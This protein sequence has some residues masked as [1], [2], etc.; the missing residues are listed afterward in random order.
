M[1][2]WMLT[3]L[4]TFIISK[5]IK[6]PRNLDNNKIIWTVRNNNVLKWL[7]F[8]NRE[9]ISNSSYYRPLRKVLVRINHLKTNDSNSGNK[10]MLYHPPAQALSIIIHLIKTQIIKIKVIWLLSSINKR[11]YPLAWTRRSPRKKWKVVA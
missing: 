5:M 6:H 11:C 3:R 8:I 9:I 7:I 4:S 2:K 10:I 1:M